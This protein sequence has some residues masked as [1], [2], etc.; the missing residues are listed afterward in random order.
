MFALSFLKRLGVVP[1]AAPTT[2]I[3]DGAASTDRALRKAL[4]RAAAEADA[5]LVTPLLEFRNFGIPLKHHWTT[6]VNSAE[7]GTDYFTRTAVAR[8]NTFINRPREARYFYQD[9]DRRGARLNGAKPYTFTFR[10]GELPP[11]KGFWSLTVYNKQHFFAANELDR[12]SI[13][14]KSRELAYAANGSL[15]LYVRHERPSEERIVNWLPAPVE[16]FSLYLRAYWPKAPIAEGR[17]TPPPVVPM[18]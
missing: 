8:S 15:T 6:V 3:A 1:R 12:F 4:K 5:T 16:D 17:W 10:K 2:L 9:L 7:F 11:V 14:T 13:G 18:D